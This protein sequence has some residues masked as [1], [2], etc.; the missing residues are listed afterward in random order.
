MRILLL[1]GTRKGGFIA[2]ADGARGL[3]VHSMAFPRGKPG[4]MMVGVSAAGAFRTDDDGATWTP[5]NTGVRADF[6]PDKFPEVGQ[7]LHHLEM[8]PQAPGVFYQQNHCGV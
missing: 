4:Q 7:C 2:S 6:M 8:H 1:I 5:K 3:M